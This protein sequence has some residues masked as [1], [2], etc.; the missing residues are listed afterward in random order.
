MDKK[1]IGNTCRNATITLLKFWKKY[2]PM[3]ICQDP[4]PIPTLILQ[5]ENSDTFID[6]LIAYLEK[7][8]ND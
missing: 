8:N 1:T 7:Q 4:A 3:D 5:K 2:V 6:K